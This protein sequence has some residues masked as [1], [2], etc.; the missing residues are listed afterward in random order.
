MFFH[1]ITCYYSSAT[2]NT[3]HFR[4]SVLQKQRLQYDLIE[5]SLFVVT[6]VA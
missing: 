1:L 5:H 2:D 4:N 6:H 3:F